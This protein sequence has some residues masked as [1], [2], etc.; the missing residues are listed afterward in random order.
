MDNQ[1]V[2]V[3]IGYGQIGSLVTEELLAR[4]SRVRVVRRGAPGTQREGLEWRSGDVS[5]LAFAENA[6][7]GASVV[8]DC[9][10]PVYDQWAKLLLPLGRGVLHGATR[11]GARLVALD[12]LYMYGRCD[13]PMTPETPMRPVSR[14]GELRK[15]LAEIRLA[16]HARGEAR[17]AIL[18]ASDFF[19]P[20]VGPGSIFGERFFERVLKGQAAECMGSPDQPHSYS[21]MPDVARALVLLGDDPAAFGRV[22]H[23]PTNP[24]E[25][26]R[27][28]I[29]RFEKEFGQK[30]PIT[31]LSDWFLKGLGVF[32]P[33]LRELSEMT[34]QW[35]QPFVLDDSAFRS[36]FGVTPT[37]LDEA[38]RLSARWAEA[39]Y[40][41]NKPLRKAI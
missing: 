21:F 22:W 25:S 11:A 23:A 4:G 15:E 5:D 7:A 27:S 13:G 14:K 30:I 12:N 41:V 37:P 19:G 33:M 38:V 29:L 36:H 24:A 39:H 20:R 17:V 18:R 2:H 28:M 10:N 35:K 32:A 34:Y 6:L 3:V 16:A 26:S 40:G 9:S 1:S 8:Y 31:V